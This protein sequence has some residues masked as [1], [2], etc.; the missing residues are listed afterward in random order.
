MTD[1]EHEQEHEQE[2]GEAYFTTGFSYQR[3]KS[4]YSQI[5]CVFRR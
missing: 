2:R 1:F 5:L 4:E 3:N